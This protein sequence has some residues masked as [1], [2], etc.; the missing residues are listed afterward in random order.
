MM[1]NTKPNIGNRFV[2]GLVDYILIYGFFFMYV[3]YVGSPNDEGGYTVSGVLALV[4]ILFWGI[5]TVGME[6]L[7]GATIGNLLVGL[8]PISLIKDEKITFL[9]SLKRHLLD[10]IDMFLFGLIGYITIKNT[11]KNQRLGDIWANTIVINISNQ[12][13]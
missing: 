3:Y 5:I 12:K 7:F 2:A 13:N 8:K 10:P 1:Y 6:Q 9:Q 4:P 11:E